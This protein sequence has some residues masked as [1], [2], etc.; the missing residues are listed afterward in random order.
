MGLLSASPSGVQWAGEGELWAPALRC[1]IPVG[2]LRQFSPLPGPSWALIGA[3]PL[4][5][6]FLLRGVM[7]PPAAP[8]GSAPSVV[9]FHKLCSYCCKLFLYLPIL[10]YHLFLSRILTT[11]IYIYIFR[12][13]YLLYKFGYRK[14]SK[15]FSQVKWPN[16]IY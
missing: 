6:P 8:P 13:I 3:P 2:P 15:V 12:Y 5:H 10:S 1:S 7:A 11:Y 9:G 4:T 16:S 14:E